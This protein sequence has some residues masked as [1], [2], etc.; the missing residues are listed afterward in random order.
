MRRII[1]TLALTAAALGTMTA[2]AAAG[3]ISSEDCVEGGGKPLYSDVTE[4]M[5]LG[6]FHSGAYLLH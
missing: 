5:C 4:S 2:P 1:A 6:G 3:H